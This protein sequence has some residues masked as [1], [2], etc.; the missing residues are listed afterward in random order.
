MENINSSIPTSSEPTPAVASKL[1]R[2]LVFLLLTLV[3]VIIGVF[4]WQ[5]Y[6]SQKFFNKEPV[7]EDKAV[8]K[9]GEELIYQQDL[10]QVQIAVPTGTPGAS[11]SERKLNQNDALQILVAQSIILQGARDDGLVT[12]DTTVFNSKDKNLRKRAELVNEINQKINDRADG[13]RGWIFSF[14][15]NTLP[16]TT[17]E[18]DK[19]LAYNKVKELHDQIKTG[20]ITFQQAGENIKND[21]SLSKITPDYQNQVPY[22]FWSKS[23]QPITFFPK[24]D[25]I[26]YSLKQGE[27]SDIYQARGSDY[28]GGKV[29][30]G[31]SS[32]IQEDSGETAY[33]FGQ[34]TSIANSGKPDAGTWFEGKSKQYEVTYY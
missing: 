4:S 28:V 33:L 9:V 24:F 23:P 17:Y 2:R 12:L 31:T 3:A 16:G 22:Q 7:L 10:Q 19:T 21:S 18:Q 26:L 5:T 20:K 15:F 32:G 14:R 11:V 13:T 8:A 29:A 6:F 1:P 30:E 25:K 27:T 34:I